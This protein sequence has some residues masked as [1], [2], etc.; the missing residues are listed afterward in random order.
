M[1]LCVYYVNERTSE[2][3]NKWTIFLKPTVRSH[4]HIEINSRERAA[5][6][7]ACVVLL[8]IAFTNNNNKSSATV[9]AAA[10]AAAFN[11]YLIYSAKT[12]H[13]AHT[14]VCVLH[15]FILSTIL[16]RRNAYISNDGAIHNSSSSNEIYPRQSDTNTKRIPTHWTHTHTD[17]TIE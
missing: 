13:T 6:L 14:F 3:T 15:I 11:L 10:A 1:V 2:R 4:S 9:T 16:Y 12:Q 7:A 5:A 17:W 8:Y